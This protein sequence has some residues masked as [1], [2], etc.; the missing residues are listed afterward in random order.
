MNNNSAY[1][2][3]GRYQHQS[4]V[5]GQDPDGKAYVLSFVA[6]VKENPDKLFLASNED[7]VREWIG[8][9]KNKWVKPKDV[10]YVVASAKRAF[11][12]SDPIASAKKKQKPKIDL[13]DV[14]RLNEL[15]QALFNSPPTWEFEIVNPCPQ[16]SWTTSKVSIPKQD[17]VFCGGGS[18]KNE[19]KVPAAKAAL[20]YLLNTKRLKALMKK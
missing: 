1:G 12:T 5:I 16:H 11:S 13:T 6:E 17:K 15:C 3:N 19:S 2:I 20:N 7:L 9:L 14:V 10:K 8:C 4:Y 18:S